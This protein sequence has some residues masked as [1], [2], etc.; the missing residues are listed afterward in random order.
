MTTFIIKKLPY[1]PSPNAGLV[2]IGKYLGRVN[3]N[4]LID[5]KFP[6]RLRAFKLLWI[7]EHLLHLPLPLS[8]PRHQGGQSI[9]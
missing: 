5:P 2:F 4:S 6:M 1:D 7:G 9:G 3:V 8:H